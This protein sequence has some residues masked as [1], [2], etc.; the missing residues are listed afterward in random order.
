[1]RDF[2]WVIIESDHSVGVRD[3]VYAILYLLISLKFLFS[4]KDYICMRDRCKK[5]FFVEQS[6][7]T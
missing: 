2:Q 6:S 5:I 4:F 7:L 1:M 3:M